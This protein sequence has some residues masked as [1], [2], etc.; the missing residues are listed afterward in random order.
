MA[1]ITI[2]NPKPT[3]HQN[4]VRQVPPSVSTAPPNTGATIGASP[5]S[6][7]MIDITF[8]SRSP[9]AT[10]TTTARATTAA[11]PPPKPCTTRNAMSIQIDG[12]NAQPTAP[13]VQISPPTIIGIRRP[14]WS[15]SGPPSSCPNAMPRKNVVKVRP[16]SDAEVARS[17]VTWG[18]AG[19]YMSVAN[20]GTALCNASVNTKDVDTAAPP[21]PARPADRTVGRGDESSRAVITTPLQTSSATKLVGVYTSNRCIS[22]QF[23][24]RSESCWNWRSWGSWPRD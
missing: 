2:N 16:T 1:V 21:A 6:A 8:A 7:I 18:K 23:E 15:D 19:V 20:G 24:V 10:S 22:D 17:A 5:P 11:K 4:T 13:R 12:A 3:R 9:F 14:R